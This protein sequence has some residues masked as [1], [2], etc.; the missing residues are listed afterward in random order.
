M[1]SSIRFLQPLSLCVALLLG[2][3]TLFAQNTIHVPGDQATIQGAINAANNGD[4]VLV[5]PGTYYENINFKG[6]AITVTSSGGAAVTIIDGGN[7]E[8]VVTF[9][10][11]EGPSSWLKGFTLQH[12]TASPNN[13]YRGGGIYVSGG[14]PTITNNVVQ[15]NTSC[16]GGFGIGLYFSSPLIQNNSIANNNDRGVGCSGGDGAGVLVAGAGT[17]QIIGNVIAN[18]AAYS[19]NGGG[20]ALESAGNA[21]VKNNIISGNNAT[22]LSPASQGGGIYSEGNTNDTITQNIIYNNS[23]DQGSGIFSGSWGTIQNN[24]IVGGSGPSGLGSAI[25]SISGTQLQ[26]FNNLLIGFSGQNAVYCDGTFSQQP[27][28]FSN[29]DAFSPSGTGFGGTCSSAGS[30]NG[31]ISVDPMFVNPTNQDFHLQSSSPAIDAGINSAPDLPQTDYDGKP[32]IMDGNNDC[33]S[34]VDIGAYE[35]QRA[36]SVTF[37]TNSLSFGNQVIGTSSSAQP[38]T[39]TNSGNTCFQFSNTQIT[40]DFSQS[41]TCDVAGVPGGS[42]CSYYV[43]FS[44]VATGQRSGALNVDGSD[45]AST[46]NLNV[47]LSGYGLTAQPSLTL[48]SASLTFAAQLVG[49]SSAVQTVT[50]TSTGNTALVFSG[51]SVSGPFAQT[52]NC[53]SSLAPTATCTISISFHPTAGGSQ[54]GLLSITDN[55]SGSPQKATLSGAG[56]D[57]SIAANPTSASVKHGQSVK[58]TVAVT[59]VGGAFSSSVALSCSGLPAGASCAFS[60]AN[61]TPGANGATSALTFSTTG[62]T[63]RGNYNILIVGRS[64]TDVQSLQILVSV[65]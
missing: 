15:N 10:S 42:S 16:G 29:N 54:S 50:L 64:G 8:S 46:R 58:F 9:S 30:L 32:R 52:N 22:G 56:V 25:Y 47:S 36:A 18:N 35:L 62:K 61:V 3:A 2:A 53:P 48:S 65:N 19:G 37:S 39:F 63:P 7:K 14:S 40:G 31:N 38:V 21:L 26:F 12:G 43:A 23:A 5:A 6:K 41:N 27:S 1:P 24:T 11:G 49:T 17:A 28:S 51:V 4:T 45:G 55:G 33:V 34:T 60:P 57:F 44:P 13:R 20:V 59:P